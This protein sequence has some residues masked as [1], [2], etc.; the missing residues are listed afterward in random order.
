MASLPS[1]VHRVTEA[2][3]AGDV[4]AAALALKMSGLLA[5]LSEPEA[6]AADLDAVQRHMGAIREALADLGLVETA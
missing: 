6:D 2:A 5:H 3:L 4:R 1:V